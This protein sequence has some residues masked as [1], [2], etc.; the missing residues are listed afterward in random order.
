MAVSPRLRSEIGKTRCDV[1][2]A[3]QLQRPPSFGR[4]NGPH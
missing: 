2:F 4:Q 1:A 3:L